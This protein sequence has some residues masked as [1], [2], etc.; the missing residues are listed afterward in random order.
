[1]L[2][3]LEVFICKSSYILNNPDDFLIYIKL[4]FYTENNFFPEVA[5]YNNK[6]DLCSQAHLALSSLFICR[7]S[8]STMSKLLDLSEAKCP[9]VE[10]KDE[11]SIY[12]I[13]ILCREAT[14]E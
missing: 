13:E 8:F 1:M 11:N 7:T 4:F 12:Y 9:Q 14:D 6:H 5:W 2:Y 3:F 10:N